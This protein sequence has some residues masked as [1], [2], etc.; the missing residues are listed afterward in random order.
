MANPIIKTL[1][2]GQKVLVVP[3]RILYMKPDERNY[4]QDSIK[5]IPSPV[6]EYDKTI[7]EMEPL[8]GS[9]RLPYTEEYIENYE[10]G[11]ILLTNKGVKKLRDLMQEE[12]NEQEKY[13]D[14]DFR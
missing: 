2:G 6:V 5:V 4:K 7:E 14:E 12:Y 3:Y 11:G 13:R 9:V 10:D 8:Y 1:E